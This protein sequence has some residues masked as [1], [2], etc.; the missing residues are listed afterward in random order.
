MRGG[1][2][3]TLAAAT[4]STAN[5]GSAPAPPAPHAAPRAAVCSGAR[6]GAVAAAVGGEGVE[7]F[8]GL[9]L[10]ERTMRKERWEQ[11]MSGKRYSRFEKLSS[12]ADCSDDVVAV[13]IMYERALPKSSS[14]GDR[15]THW[16]L[17]DFSWPQ[18]RMMTLMLFGEAFETWENDPEKQIGLGSAFAIL[19][20]VV[21]GERG[22][23]TKKPTDDARCRARVSHGSQLVLLGKFPSLGFCRCNKKDGTPCS[24]P[25]DTSRGPLVC[26]YH[27]LHQAAQ[28]VKRWQGKSGAGSATGKTTGSS[29]SASSDGLVVWQKPTPSAS[30]RATAA[31]APEAMRASSAPPAPIKAS[32]PVTKVPHGT[33]LVKDRAADASMMR[34]LSA[35]S[36]PPASARPATSGLGRAVVSPAGLNPGR[37]SSAGGLAGTAGAGAPAIERRASGN[38]A[39]GVSAE[40]APR[41][42]VTNASST[43]D[44]MNAF[45]EWA[46][47]QAGANGLQGAQGGGSAV[48]AA[49]VSQVRRQFPNG[50]PAPDPNTTL[51]PRQPLAEIQEPLAEAPARTVFKVTPGGGRVQPRLGSPGRKR[52][53][54]MKSIEAQFGKKVALQLA[55]IDPRKDPIRQQVSRFQGMVDQEHAAKRDRQ[56]AELEAQ[57]EMQAKM[58]A[59]MHISVQAWRCSI[60][61]TLTDSD[62]ARAACAAAGHVLAAVI[63]KKERWQC[64]GCSQEVTVLNRQLPAHCA[65]CNGSS[66]RQVPLSRV[67]RAT[68][69]KDLL[70]PRGEEMKFVNSVP[71]A[72]T[73][74]NWRQPR[75]AHDEYGSLDNPLE[76]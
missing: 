12:L 34:L 47:S 53:A 18:P 73:Q 43:A 57:D 46:R 60:C 75:E 42:V 55:A 48:S 66:F 23:E 9:R 25:C 71:T 30:S 54:A 31:A 22:D 49:T 72:A 39:P 20:P 14:T 24:M 62:R 58:E 5:A 44:N 8:S 17:T 6:A 10:A 15:Y 33:G 37:S 13:G 16:T 40:A 63:A 27:S 67:R 1:P 11:L 3:A 19:N 74:R 45:M 52:A 65:R 69:D 61:S 35:S 29:G 32:V 56:L 26:Y 64:K 41:E 36:R 2:R 51:Q 68:M 76:T 70:L 28:Q 38:S 50:I 7:P 59:M 21:M 4:R